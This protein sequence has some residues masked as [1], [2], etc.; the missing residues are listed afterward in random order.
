MTICWKWSGVRSQGI[1]S[2]EPSEDLDYHT[3]ALTGM[4]IDSEHCDFSTYKVPTREETKDAAGLLGSFVS[5]T[6]KTSFC[7]MESRTVGLVPIR[8]S[9]GD[10]VC[11][12]RGC[13]VPFVLCDPGIP[14]T[15]G[16]IGECY[17]R[18]LMKGKIMQPGRYVEDEL[19]FV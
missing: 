17:V 2:V 6:R 19:R 8:A 3:K 7:V 4:I 11:V 16:L 9:P 5:M 15:F 14:G 1:G 18:G 10:G 13:P 12:L